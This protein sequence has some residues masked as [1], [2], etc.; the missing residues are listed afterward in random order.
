MGQHFWAVGEKSMGKLL[1]ASAGD[2]VELLCPPPTA[3]PGSRPIFQGA[4]KP[5]PYGK[6]STRRGNIWSEV[7]NKLAINVDHQ[8]TY[9]NE[10][11]L[12]LDCAVTA[13]T[14]GQHAI[15]SGA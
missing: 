4:P 2:D 9:D 13:K 6:I 1:V 15:V 7:A 3:Q 10:P 5:A 11:L 14:L 8:L 12:V